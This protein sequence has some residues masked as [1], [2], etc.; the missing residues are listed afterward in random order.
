MQTKGHALTNIIGGVA[1]RCQG[2]ECGDFFCKPKI[3]EFEEGVWPFGGVQQILW[4]RDEKIALH[5]LTK[6]VHKICSALRHVQYNSVQ[7]GFTL[8]SL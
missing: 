6:H 1:W 4:L 2:V 3:G 7:T 8:M 5:L